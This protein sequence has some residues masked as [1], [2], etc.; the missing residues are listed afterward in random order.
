MEVSQ[1]VLGVRGERGGFLFSYLSSH[2]FQFELVFK[3][4]GEKQI[5]G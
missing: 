3:R 2:L 4:S 1:G 5:S